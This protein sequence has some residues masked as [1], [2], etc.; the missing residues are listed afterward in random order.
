M[1]SRNHVILYQFQLYSNLCQFHSLISNF[2]WQHWPPRPVPPCHV[3]VCLL[4]A[5]DEVVV[6]VD[7]DGGDPG[8]GAGVEDALRGVVDDAAQAGGIHRFL[9]EMDASN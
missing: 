5:V 6:D 7:V 1:P 9:T 2:P 4:R 8:G 3:T